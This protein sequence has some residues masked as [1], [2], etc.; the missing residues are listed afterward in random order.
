MSIRV[1]QALR[2]AS[3]VH[4]GFSTIAC[5]ALANQVAGLYGPVGQW[6]K[7]LKQAVVHVEENTADRCALG[8]RSDGLQGR[9]ELQRAPDAS[10]TLRVELDGDRPWRFERSHLTLML[11]GSRDVY[12]AHRAAQ[13][14]TLLMKLRYGSDGMQVFVLAGAFMHH[15]NDVLRALAP[16]EVKLGTLSPRPQPWSQP[17]SHAQSQPQPRSQPQSHA[18]PQPQP[19]SQPQLHAQPQPWP[20]AVAGE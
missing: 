12:V 5:E 13:G 4:L 1:D 19:R 6:M 20:L 7:Q 14:D 18:Q 9:V 3:G 16:S 8:L 17:Q 15:L 10:F 11:G 2:F